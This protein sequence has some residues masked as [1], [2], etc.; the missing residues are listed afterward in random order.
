M[1]AANKGKIAY[2]LQTISVVPMLA[3]GIITLFLSYSWFTS[4]MYDEVAQELR[5]VAVN[6]NALMEAVYPGD[7]TCVQNATAESAPQETLLRLCKGGVEISGTHELL[8]KMKA[9]SDLEITIFYQDIR[10]L[11]TLY[12]TTG[13][14]IVNTRAPE[15]VIADVLQTGEAKF[16]HQVLVNGSNYFAYYMPLVNSDGSTVGMIFVGK[17]SSHVNAAIQKSLYP[18]VI[19][20]V[21]TML[22]ISLLLFC[23]TKRLVASLQRVRR[24][25]AEV[26]LGNLTAELDASVISRRDEFGDIGRSAISMQRSLRTMVEQDALTEL[27]NRRYAE[28]R[29]R[30]IIAKNE[31]LQTP[32][33]VAIG[34]I[35]F[36]KKVN[37]AYGHACGDLVLKKV[38]A[39]LK[40]S[41]RPCGFAS[42]WGGEEFLLVFENTEAVEAHRILTALLDDIRSMDCEYNGLHVKVTV[43]FGLVKAQT[44]DITQILKLADE[45][46]YI[47][48]NDGRNRI[49]WDESE[50]M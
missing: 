8:D 49:V 9:D 37:D 6:V 14:R 11:T 13:G 32:L 1:G 28:R 5:Y 38:S 17:P 26:A 4:T 40:E 45:R 44:P 7:Y 31:S 23:Y 12:S 2:V 30:Q 33:C 43:T 15:V 22:L 3:F 24:F 19:A 27:Y 47:G 20:T 34:D 42:R 36:F 46:L 29:L 48:K 39:K 21:I 18:L 10:I 50:A 16:Y 35:D 41:M 25:L